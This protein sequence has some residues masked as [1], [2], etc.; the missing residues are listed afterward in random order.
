MN[1]AFEDVGQLNAESLVR[2]S[3]SLTGLHGKGHC[4]EEVA[5]SL[6]NHFYELFRAT[7][8][9]PS[10]CSLVRLFKTCAVDELPQ[11]MRPI[12]PED[13]D[14]EHEL[15]CLVLLGSRGDHPDWNSRHDSTNHK[16]ISLQSV[17]VVEQTPMISNLIR[18]L[19]LNLHDIVKPNPELSVAGYYPLSVFYVE[20]ALESPYIP[21][22]TNF[23]IP[24][25]IKSVVGFGGLLTYSDMFTI[26]LFFNVPVSREVAVLFKNLADQV[27]QLL[28]PF[29]TAMQI[30]KPA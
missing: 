21:S 9:A 11:D 5:D 26:V 8:D 12:I 7:P 15:R 17:D 24:H 2:V 29:Q 22:K 30:F 1:A 10:Q 16:V 28:M 19:G 14:L 25:G 18:M 20:D 13:D 3:R 27:H 6:A 23:V 4:M